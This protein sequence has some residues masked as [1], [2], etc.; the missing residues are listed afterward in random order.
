MYS[1]NYH[2]FIEDMILSEIFCLEQRAYDLFRS[3][4]AQSF[5]L[6]T[7]KTTISP[8]CHVRTQT[9]LEETL[10]MFEK[11]IPTPCPNVQP[12]SKT[13]IFTFIIGVL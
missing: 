9:F 8:T 11:A 13:Y 5:A 10:Q 7:V 2:I 4:I 1:S 3:T 12:F 6:R